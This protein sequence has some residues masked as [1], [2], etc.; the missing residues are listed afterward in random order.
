[1]SYNVSDR[2]TPAPRRS[3]QPHNRPTPMPRHNRS[4]LTVS[5]AAESVESV[6][7]ALT[8]EE[9][10][11]EEER[12]EQAVREA[13]LEL[14]RVKERHR[15]QLSRIRN[16][17]TSSAISDRE[18]ETDRDM[19]RPTKA[20]PRVVSPILQQQ[21]SSTPTRLY[22]QEAVK[23]DFTIFDGKYEEFPFFEAQVDEAVRLRYSET[24]ILRHLKERLRG[25]AF[26]AVHG[27]L[28]TGGSF[29][30]VRTISKERFGD[31]QIIVNRTVRKLME[32]A[33]LKE[34]DIDALERFS[35]DIS[36]AVAIIRHVGQS[37]ELNSLQVMQ[38]LTSKLPRD[39]R[40][41]WGSYGRSKVEGG[42]L[43][44][45]LFAAFLKAHI[46]DRRFCSG[47]GYRQL[48]RDGSDP[49]RKGNEPKTSRPRQTTCA[50]EQLKCFFCE[51][52]HY[53]QRCDKFKTL[54]VDE[55]HQWIKERRQC[56]RCLSTGHSTST[57]HR[58][59][60]CGLGGCRELHHRMLHGAA[61]EMS[62][63]VIGAT[64]DATPSCMLMKTCVIDIN[65]VTPNGKRRCRAF[66]D[67]G[68][69][70]TLMDRSLA[71]ELKLSGPRCSMDIKTVTGVKTVETVTVSMR[72]E[73][74]ENGRKFRLAN[75]TC[76][77]DLR[78]SPPAISNKRLRMLYQEL[79]QLNLPELDEA[80]R[81]LIGLD[82]AELIA[83]R[84][85]RK[86]KKNGPLLQRTL[87]GWTVTGRVVIREDKAEQL[88][89]VNFLHTDDPWSTE[90]FGCKYQFETPFSPE[91]RKAEKILNS[92][93]YHEGT[94]W[95][96][97]LLRR[98]RAAPFPPSRQMATK[99]AK[100]FEKRLE[101]SE[102]R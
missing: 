47:A 12:L 52:P 48:A 40:H 16:G 79:E 45:D 75:V 63:E 66:L 102:L 101:K 71:D 70:V 43:T 93:V 61:A 46:K 23:L 98:D 85:V 41:E 84:E 35:T 94:R 30:D 21:R 10:I 80:P 58:R 27:A 55:R 90:K 81:I 3:L 14:E 99:R 64:Q 60:P 36:N 76:V 56:L 77:R 59:R 34:G 24:Q 100:A 31:P 19:S 17:D 68:S 18:Y 73:N 26:E 57:C 33:P 13:E 89:E 7:A 87:L 86:T 62:S 5:E 82:Q 51:Q 20:E 6:N 97:P 8:R 32:T 69:S 78:L 1:M 74:P 38:V 50:T 44:C 15:L 42:T 39:S 91:D 96:A 29:G 11:F 22:I 2:P 49:K 95:V 72:I 37:S 53:I 25:V 4:L 9:Q 92:E 88:P 65:V 28:L 54:S 67:E 83:T